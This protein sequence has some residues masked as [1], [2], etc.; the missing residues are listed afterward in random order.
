M[1]CVFCKGD[2]DS[3]TASFIIAETV[4][5]FHEEIEALK[6]YHN[7]EADYQ[8]ALSQEDVLKELGLI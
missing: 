2:I 6:A 5:P 4:A 3:R 1:T 8:P 7:G